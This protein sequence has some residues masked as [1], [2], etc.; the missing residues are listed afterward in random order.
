M[1]VI[2]WNVRGFNDPL[3]QKRVIARIRSINAKVV[4]LLETKVKENNSRS[5]IDHHFQGWG[6]LH[7]YSEAYN[8]RIWVLWHDQVSVDLMDTTAQCISYSIKMSSNQFYMS[9][10]YGYNEGLA[11]R[12]L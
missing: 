11:R 10:V 6:W 4:C 12:S 1:T 7:N 5:I 8:G 2:V 9:I 3:K